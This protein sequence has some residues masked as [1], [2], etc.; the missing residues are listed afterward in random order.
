L[1]KKGLEKAEGMQKQAENIVKDKFNM[2]DF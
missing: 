2:L 1:I